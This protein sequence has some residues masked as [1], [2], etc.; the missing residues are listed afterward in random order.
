MGLHCPDQQGEWEVC[1]FGKPLP[2]RARQEVSVTLR[3]NAMVGYKQV[4]PTPLAV[5]GGNSTFGI[6]HL[7]CLTSQSSLISP[8]SE[9]PR[10]SRHS[11]P[12]AFLILSSL[13]VCSS[14]FPLL[15]SP[16]ET[17][18][19]RRCLSKVWLVPVKYL[20]LKSGCLSSAH[21]RNGTGTPHVWWMSDPEGMI[22]IFKNF[23]YISRENQTRYQ[24]C[25]CCIVSA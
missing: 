8:L 15:R 18:T 21:C 7:P 24:F 20:S 14:H 25:I 1:L 12:C 6:C 9:S 23:L 11:H 2:R 10:P 13:L 22:V 16:R 5:G 3:G 19:L 17:I 4:F